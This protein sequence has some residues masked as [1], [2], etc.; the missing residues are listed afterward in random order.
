MTCGSGH[1]PLAP[2]AAD[3]RWTR[4]IRQTDG[5]V[6]GLEWSDWMQLLFYFLS[7]ISRKRVC[8]VYL[9]IFLPANFLI[10]LAPCTPSGSVTCF[11]CPLILSII[12]SYKLL[13]LPCSAVMRACSP[14]PP[15]TRLFSSTSLLE[16][17]LIFALIS[18]CF[19]ACSCMRVIVK[20]IKLSGFL[21]SCYQW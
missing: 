12:S 5:Q 16:L 3:S 21:V 17:A 2:T 9:S 7:Y 11:F 14:P 4:Y 13:I 15:P 19:M 20:Q 1:T 10:S 18:G 8:F 6:G